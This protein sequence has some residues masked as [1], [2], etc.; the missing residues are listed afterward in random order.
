VFQ[1]TSW[2]VAAF[3]LI[4]PSAMS[5]EDIV[6]TKDSKVQGKVTAVSPTEV[7]VSQGGTEKKVPVNKIESISYEED[8]T[9]IR[10]GR[11][12]A[13]AKRYEEA[14]RALENV[15]I[16]EIERPEL[17]QD[18][19]Y[20]SALSAAK[21]ALSG[22]AEI[23]E[24]GKQMR[25]FLAA[26]PQSCHYFEANEVVGDLLVALDQFAKAREYYERVGKAPW[27][28]YKLR[29]AAAMGKV[30]LAEDKP[31]EALK[32][33]QHVLDANA[34]SDSATAQRSA[35]ALGKARCL[36]E[37]DKH[38]EAIKVAEAIIAEADA[39]DAEDADLLGRAY[40]VLGIAFEKA[41]RLQDAQYALLHVDAMYASV[42]DVHAE[43]LFRLARVWTALKKP[44]RALEARRTLADQYGD[45]RWG[46]E[47]GQRY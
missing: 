29:A 20:Y 42:R 7:T 23:P 21:L 27:P 47:L 13:V 19:E 30:L 31:A 22:K 1:R 33:F 35:A 26:Y 10:R 41:G 9:F 24:A 34:A 4:A 32:F 6:K 37:T 25:Q 36:A 38:A 15:K 14:Y 28:E 39:E 40:L 46:R 43:S 44:D 16:D 18:V 3:L 45:T 5:A 12:A 2:I 8:S 11:E 17:K